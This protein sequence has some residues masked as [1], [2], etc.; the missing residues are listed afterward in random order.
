[1]SIGKNTIDARSPERSAGP[2]LVLIGL[3]LAGLLP[4]LAALGLALG[5]RVAFLWHIIPVLLLAAA[6]LP[7][8]KPG[9][10]GLVLAVFLPLQHLLLC[11]YHTARPDFLLLTKLL[12][13]WKD[14]A[15]VGVIVV[16]FLSLRALRG[17]VRLWQL[18]VAGFFALVA[19]LVLLSPHPVFSRLASAR[20]A[21]VP[22]ILLF[23]GYAAGLSDGQLRRTV[24]VFFLVAILVTLFGFF[25]RT[26]L[27]VQ[28]YHALSGVLDFVDYRNAVYETGQTTR[29]YNLLH[30]WGFGNMRRMISVMF[31]VIT[32]ATYLSFVFCM[33][34]ACV[35]HGVVKANW[36][37]LLALGALGA[38][39]YLTAA[40]LEI[41][42]VFL[43]GS[44]YVLVADIGS[45]LKYAMLF[46][47]GAGLLTV[48]FF[49]QL[50]SAVHGTIGMGDAST[51]QHF[52]S[53]WHLRPSLLGQ[54]LGVGAQVFWQGKEYTV[55]EGVYNRLAIEIGVIGFAAFILCY[56]AITAKLIIQRTQ[57]TKA[58]PIRRAV[59]S[60][61]I[62]YAVVSIP[63]IFIN[64]NVLSTIATGLFWFFAGVAL[65]GPADAQRAPAGAGSGAGHT[66][67]PGEEDTA[68]GGPPCTK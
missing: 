29:V 55:A 11:L 25:E 62:V 32:L 6:F 44:Y 41:A 26:F 58:S 63:S 4:I 30:A 66:A 9:A 61:S 3:L 68:L 65:R 39:V 2:G 24:K 13:V 56:M 48:M 1:V 59:L 38:A 50:V 45:K 15:A 27:T 49:P 17:R 35:H 40:R 22:F 14:L 31:S 10:L 37:T 21:T 20:T 19:G 57:P 5:Q 52:E 8:V 47:L 18:M 42:M 36:W 46:V 12:T 28:D 7:W 33:G 60:A 53:I 64:M 43:I 54:G 23:A 16:A 67:A 51:R 34:L